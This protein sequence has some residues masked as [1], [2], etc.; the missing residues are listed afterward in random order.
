MDYP[1]H[2]LVVRPLQATAHN[3]EEALRLVGYS[4]HLLRRFG[5]AELWRLPAEGERPPQV[6]PI[7][8]ELWALLG[9]SVQFRWH[10]QRADSPTRGAHFELECHQP[11]LVLAPFGVEFG[12]RA[13]GSAAELVRLA[14]HEHDPKDG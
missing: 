1:I 14:S 2:D 6:R 13:L 4:D 8:D 10:D 5:L 9:G 12:I 11:T 3:G 7:A